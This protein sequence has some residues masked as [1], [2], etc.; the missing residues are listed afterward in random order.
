LTLFSVDALL[1]AIGAPSR[2]GSFEYGR[3]VFFLSLFPRTGTAKR[4]AGRPFWCVDPRLF[5]FFF[6]PFP[7]RT[8]ETIPAPGFFFC[9]EVLPD[10]TPFAAFKPRVT[11]SRTL[12]S[13]QHFLHTPFFLTPSCFLMTFP[14]SADV[15]AAMLASKDFPAVFIL[16]LG[17]FFQRPPKPPRGLGCR[18]TFEPPGFEGL[19]GC[20]G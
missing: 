6:H 1:E 8:W 10:H 18:S 2:R 15:G 4:F 3:F 20:C 17:F 7:L 11:S 16:F 19:V 14:C 13:W 12:H 9:F 5:S